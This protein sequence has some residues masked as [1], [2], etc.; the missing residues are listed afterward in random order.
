[1]K[2]GALAL[3]IGYSI[4]PDGAEVRQGITLL[5]EVELHEVSLVA[6]PANTNARIHSVKAFDSAK[7]DP[8]TFEQAARDALGLSAREAKRLMAGGWSGLVRD[9]QPDDSEELAA[10][11]AHIKRI[12]ATLR[13]GR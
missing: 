3:S 8:R 12:T 4:A 5:R 13:T 10:V 1:M 9:V 11:A 2:D 6:M 7:P